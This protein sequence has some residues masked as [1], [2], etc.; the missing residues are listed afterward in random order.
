[1][2]SRRVLLVAG[3]RGFTLI[4]LLVVIAIIG[5][6]I[7]LLLPAVQSAREASRRMQCTNN[8]RQ[9]ALGVHNYHDAHGSFPP[10][11]KGSAWGTWNHFI[12]PYIEQ[13]AVYNA[14]NDIGNSVNGPDHTHRYFGATNLTVAT[15]NI[16]T[17]LCPSDEGTNRNNSFAGT[18]AGVRYECKFR[19]YVVNLGTT[20]DGQM[21]FPSASTTPILIFRGAPFYDIGSPNVASQAFM[22]YFG[23]RRPRNSVG[24]ASLTDGTSSTLMVSEVIMSQGKQDLRGF[25]QWGEATGFTGNAGPNSST[26]DLSDWCVNWDKGPPLQ[27]LARP[28]MNAN[29]KY[30]AAR[31]K[32]P[33]GVNAALCDGSVKFFKNTINIHTWRD[34]TTANGGE[35]IGADAY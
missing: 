12:L 24:L 7:A 23:F 17:Y 13:Q 15:V 8:L 16:T 20:N 5:G 29:D 30:L 18:L 9:I 2:M 35:V 25:T 6:L 22:P 28:M 27:C 3:R 14:W 11:R 32:H 10:A 4:E 34:L 26:P 31:S 1:M 19:N 21:N 33:G